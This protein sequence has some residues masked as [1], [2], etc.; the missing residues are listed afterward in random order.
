M[1]KFIHDSKTYSL[2]TFNGQSNFRKNLRNSK[3]KI[4]ILYEVVGNTKRMNL[5]S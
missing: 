1:V 4:Y 5:G 3:T 2:I